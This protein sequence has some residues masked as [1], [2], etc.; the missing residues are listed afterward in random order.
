MISFMKPRSETSEAPAEATSTSTSVIKA[1][2]VKLFSK[3]SLVRL[4]GTVNTNRSFW[5]QACAYRQMSYRGNTR[6]TLLPSLD[7]K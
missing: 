1:V 4:N 5:R 2:K 3:F 6:P 7:C